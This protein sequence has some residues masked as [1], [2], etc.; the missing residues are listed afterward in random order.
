MDDHCRKA[1]DPHKGGVWVKLACN[2]T[3]GRALLQM[4]SDSS[5]KSATKTLPAGGYAFTRSSCVTITSN[6]VMKLDW[7]PS[8]CTVAHTQV[9]YSAAP[10]PPP[11]SMYQ[12]L[13]E[14]EGTTIADVIVAVIIAAVILA[15][16]LLMFLCMAYFKQRNSV[17]IGGDE[18]GFQTFGVS[19]P[20]CM[21]PTFADSED[22]EADTFAI[23]MLD[24]I[25]YASKS[26]ECPPDLAAEYLS[27]VQDMTAEECEE[28]CDEAGFHVQGMSLAGMHH[29]LQI[30]FQKLESGEEP[31]EPVAK[32]NV[33]VEITEPGR[34]GI[35]YR[36]LACGR[37]VIGKIVKDTP[38]AA[39]NKQELTLHPGM[40]LHGVSKKPTGRISFVGGMDFHD[41]MHLITNY[42]RPIFLHFSE[43][44]ENSN[45]CLS[46]D[47]SPVRLPHTFPF[48]CGSKLEWFVCWEN[49]LLLKQRHCQSRQYYVL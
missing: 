18:D 44:R 1:G 47:R 16:L 21:M 39:I 49:E 31:A 12:K 37:I 3:D 8:A 41:A 27:M 29:C 30:Y 33:V 6:H 25:D 4:F 42:G 23:A 15:I 11:E 20:A 34:I 17:K 26:V 38:A 9:K 2:H 22:N 32:E 13:V 7:P 5:C 40:V 46:C 35:T 43:V 19:N 28:V 10:P 48:S 24:D 14:E 36:H 45:P